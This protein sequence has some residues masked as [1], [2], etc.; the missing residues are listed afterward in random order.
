MPTHEENPRLQ[1]DGKFFRLGTTRPWLRTVTYGP[2][3]P[4]KTPDFSEDFASIRA[5]NFDSVRL[6]TLPEKNLLD[7]A[8][9]AGLLVFAGIGGWEFCDFASRPAVISAA[10]VTLSCWLEKH[11]THPALAAVYVGNEIPT[12]LVRWIGPTKVRHTIEDLIDLGRSIAPHLLFAYANFPSTE[13]LEPANADFSAFNVYLEHKEDFAS[14]LRRL[15]NIAGDRPLIISEFGM[16]SSRNSPETQAETIS[17][18]LAT[19]HKEETAGITIFSWSDL[20]QNNNAEVTDWNFGLTDREGNKKPSYYACSKFLPHPPTAPTHKYSVIICTRN[21]ASRIAT[22][23]TSIENLS[24]PPHETIVVDDGSTDDTS[25]IVSKNFPAVR[26]IT[27]PPSGLSHARNTGAAAATGEILAFTDDD[28][29]P[30]TEWLTRLDKAFQNPA[31]SA[32]GGPNLPPPPNTP[33]EAVIHAAPGAPTHVLLTDTRAEHLPGCNI[34]VR[35]ITFDVIGG[36]DPIFQTAG[37]DVDFCWRLTDTGH[38]MTFVPGAFVWHHRRPSILAFLKQQIGYG[39]AEKILLEKHPHRFSKDGEARWDGFIYG[40]GPIRATDSSVIY[41]GSMGQ[42]G[43]QS[44]I[45]NMQPLRP[46]ASQHKTLTTNLRTSTLKI[47]QPATRR[48]FRNKTIKLPSFERKP[49]TNTQPQEIHLPGTAT[50]D[51]HHYLGILLQNG[52]HPSPPTAPWDLEKQNT[53]IL[54]ATEYFQNNTTKT[55]L[56]IWGDPK[57]LPPSLT[58]S[59]S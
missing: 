11:G 10:R 48:W 45:T 7:A 39:K 43:Y 35:K 2:F 52:W 21:G 37:D 19:S 44:V 5:A 25:S 40:G 24:H 3:P 29:E 47:L 13:Y 42:A 51:H 9:K 33:E 8:Q 20:W 56:R 53:R 17:W 16:D 59:H 12:H 31:I 26:L 57:T 55:L 6:Y 49:N 15:H 41:Y 54:L 32:A 1:T 27:I 14:Y 34:A 4:D 18:A 46:V 50:Q 36:F 28:C 58:N 38:H 30:D 22:C 23:L